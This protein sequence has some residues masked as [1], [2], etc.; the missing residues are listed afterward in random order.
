MCRINAE[1]IG[2]LKPTGG[3]RTPPNSLGENQGTFVGESS[4]EGLSREE[5][6]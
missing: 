6:A 1:F 5:K 3:D 4:E 2:K